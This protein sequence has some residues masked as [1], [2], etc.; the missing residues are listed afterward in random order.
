[1][2]Q[3]ARGIPHVKV[4]NEWHGLEVVVKEME[5]G[6]TW[7]KPLL[8]NCRMRPLKLLLS[9]NAVSRFLVSDSDMIWINEGRP[10][11][12]RYWRGVGRGSVFD[13]F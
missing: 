2:I 11:K 7:W 3:S 1:M 9:T 6:N 13:M 5:E 12:S 8:S 4:T 10:R